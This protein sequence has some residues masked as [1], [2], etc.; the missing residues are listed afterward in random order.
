MLEASTRPRSYKTAMTLTLA[1]RSR[2]SERL[3]ELRQLPLLSGLGA[4][5]L[6]RLHT[7]LTPCSFS[8]GDVITRQGRRGARILAF[9][10]IVSGEA[11]VALDGRRIRE[12]GPGDHVGEIGLLEGKARTAT[13]TAETEVC[14]LALSGWAFRDYTET[15][16]GF[17]TKLRP[18]AFR[19]QGHSHSKT[20]ERVL[21][22]SIV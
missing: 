2:P 3:D 6:E 15:T 4:A 22:G 18:R 12:L 19:P 10:I 20:S 7:Y 8:E 13:V 1:D 5:D 21:V 16:P 11:S 14:C 17:A 9:F